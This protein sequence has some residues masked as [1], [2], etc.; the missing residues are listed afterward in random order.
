MGLPALTPDSRACVQP[1]SGGY[2]DYLLSEREDEWAIL[3]NR[4]IWRGPYCNDATGYSYP[5]DETTSEEE[6]GFGS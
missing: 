3:H 2:R 1:N 4:E 5:E 6:T